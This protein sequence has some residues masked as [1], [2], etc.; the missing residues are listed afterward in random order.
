M[1][2]K[3]NHTWIPNGIFSNSK[4]R[5]EFFKSL[6]SHILHIVYKLDYGFISS[7]HNF[8]EEVQNEK[9]SHTLISGK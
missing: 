4:T 2:L 5:T 6:L 1:Q 7:L 8:T 3:K 9:D